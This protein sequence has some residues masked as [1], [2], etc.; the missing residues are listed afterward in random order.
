MKQERGGSKDGI[1]EGKS[2]WKPVDKDLTIILFT[3]QNHSAVIVRNWHLDSIL[4]GADISH[5][6]IYMEILK[7]SAELKDYFRK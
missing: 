2:S 1:K 4:D 3:I 7:K 6:I 5:R